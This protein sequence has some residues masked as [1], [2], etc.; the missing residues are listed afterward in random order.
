MKIL[1]RILIF[2][3][4]VYSLGFPLS[5]GISKVRGFIFPNPYRSLVKEV[6]RHYELDPL[7][8]A[9]LIYTESSFRPGVTSMSGAVGLMQLMPDTA[10]QVA[11]EKGLK[12]FRVEELCDAR[13]N[14]ELGCFY[15]SKLGRE[16]QNLDQVLIAYNAGRGNLL[17]WKELE[18][19]LLSQS[20][21]ETRKYVTRIRYTFWLLKLLNGIQR[22]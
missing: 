6:S 2:L 11:Q 10:L 5:V 8:V 12:N 19:D 16:F 15:L 13:T 4:V 7:L 18:K 20:F 1:A 17:K 9:A 21:P 3:M 14:L 22:F